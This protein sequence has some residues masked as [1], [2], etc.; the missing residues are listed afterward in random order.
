MER[1]VR[2]AY[3]PALIFSTAPSHR[4]T[5]FA[6]NRLHVIFVVS[7]SAPKLASAVTHTNHTMIWSRRSSE[8]QKSHATRF[9]RFGSTGCAACLLAN[10]VSTNLMVGRLSNIIL[11]AGAVRSI[12]T[13]LHMPPRMMLLRLAAHSLTCQRCLSWP[14]HASGRKW[15]VPNCFGTLYITVLN[16]IYGAPRCSMLEDICLPSIK[17]LSR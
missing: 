13:S 14:A 8:T 11:I 9:P 12:G 1:G 7:V 6:M 4:L 10:I 16:A 17:N 3:A 15:L 2:W 5:L